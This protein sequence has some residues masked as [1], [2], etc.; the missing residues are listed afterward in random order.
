MLPPTH[1]TTWGQKESYE[2]SVC[3][4]NKGMIEWRMNENN[5]KIFKIG[6]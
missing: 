5:F 1:D 3:I 6:L 4:S 2:L